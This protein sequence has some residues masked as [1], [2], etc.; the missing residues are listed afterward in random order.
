M[1]LREYGVEKKLN[2]KVKA[3]IKCTA[4][5]KRVGKKDTNTR[6]FILVRQQPVPTSSPQ[7]TYG[8]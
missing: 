7:A 1:L 6:V 2:K 5:S 3:E 8:P 4:E